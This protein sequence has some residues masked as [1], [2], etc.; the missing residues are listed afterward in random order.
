MSI[1]RMCLQYVGG[2][3]G[4][5]P[6]GDYAELIGTA[7]GTEGR[8]FVEIRASIDQEASTGCVYKYGNHLTLAL[9]EVRFYAASFH[10]LAG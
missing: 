2:V 4:E 8:R 1:Y 10:L 3:D 5:Q 9:A 6:E 7:R